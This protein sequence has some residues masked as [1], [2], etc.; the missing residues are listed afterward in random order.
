[1]IAGEALGKK[2]H[3]VVAT[4]LDVRT[5]LI[6]LEAKSAVSKTERRVIARLLVN[7]VEG[8]QRLL[9]C[10]S[11]VTTQISTILCTRADALSLSGLPGIYF[12]MS[13]VGAG[14]VSVRGPN[15]TAALADAWG[16]FVRRRYPELE[17]RDVETEDGKKARY[18]RRQGFDVVSVSLKSSTME[19]GSS[20]APKSFCIWCAIERQRQEDS[21]SSSSASESEDDAEEVDDV[22]GGADEA[23]SS[24]SGAEDSESDGESD[25]DEEATTS[26][27]AATDPSFPLCDP[28][29]QTCQMS[30]II[31]PHGGP[32]IAVIDCKTKED[33][34]SLF[35]NPH[36]RFECDRHRP[37]IAFHLSSWD[38]VQSETYQKWL[39]RSGVTKNVF[40]NEVA[41]G[42]GKHARFAS[43]AKFVSEIDAPFGFYGNEGHD[44]GDFRQFPKSFIAHGT[45]EDGAS[46]ELYERPARSIES[47]IATAATTLSRAMSLSDAVVDPNEIRLDASSPESKEKPPRKQVKVEES[48]SVVFQ[49]YPKMVFLGT[50]AAKPS[51]LRGLSCCQLWLSPDESVLFDVGEDSINQMT[52]YE[53]MYHLARFS[54]VDSLRAI[55][56][57]HHHLDHHGGLAGLLELYFQRRHDESRKLVVFAPQS[58]RLFLS[59]AFG[60]AAS[61]LE[62]IACENV[63]KHP[64]PST[65]LARWSSVRV[66]HCFD[67]HAIGVDIAAVGP[68]S[69]P[70]R[71]IYTGDTRPCVNRLTRL[72]QSLHHQPNLKSEDDSSP[73]LIL[74]HEATFEGGLLE[75]AQK[76]KHS[77][78]DEAIQVGRQLKARMLLLTHFSQ[79]YPKRIGIDDVAAEEA[80][81]KN[82]MLVMQAH[83]LL[84]VDLGR[85]ASDPATYGKLALE[86][87]RA[88]LSLGASKEP[89][90]ST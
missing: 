6:S 46:F 78:V 21:R 79:R 29:F 36:F 24:S 34:L 59:R 90:S 84:H 9:L 10:N 83:D 15:G 58:V 73:L 16:E 54:A 52:R 43:S 44:L 81:V 74:I 4:A 31:Q 40:T 42:R 41:Q 62:V 65:L 55:W 86:L 63:A 80:R 26:N 76:K 49:S 67:S 20:S 70:M 17:A 66:D 53:D 1:M 7:P 27:K 8:A 77:T 39:E 37:S 23:L 35:A 45:A 14:T 60:P 25:V 88:M 82:P 64:S 3:T 2:A 30:Y 87:N 13:D 28:S 51:T 12:A 50:G 68:S 69:S 72:C 61:F 47:S 5:V 57:S 38:L 85:F 32:L 71:V 75:E 22:K 33:V 89:E 19:T 48:S 18:E 56:V 11:V